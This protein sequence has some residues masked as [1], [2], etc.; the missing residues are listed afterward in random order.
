MADSVY[1]LFIFLFGRNDIDRGRGESSDND[2]CQNITCEKYIYW[3]IRRNTQSL[4]TFLAINQ[5]CNDWRIRFLL[6]VHRLY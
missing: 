4:W 1:F 3:Y 2:G 5:D 6:S